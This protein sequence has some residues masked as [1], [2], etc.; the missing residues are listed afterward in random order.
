[1]RISSTQI[2]DFNTRTCPFSCL[3][4]PLKLSQRATSSCSASASSVPSFC[5][6]G[7]L[8]TMNSSCLSHP[9]AQTDPKRFTLEPPNKDKS[10][11]TPNDPVGRKANTPCQS[12][13]PGWHPG[14]SL[15]QAT[16]S[17]GLRPP[18]T[19]LIMQEPS[20]STGFWWV[21]DGGIP[22]SLSR[23]VHPLP[24]ANLRIPQMRGRCSH[25]PCKASTG[26]SPKKA[27]RKEEKILAKWLLPKRMRKTHRKQG[28]PKS[29]SGSSTSR[30]GYLTLAVGIKRETK[31]A[32]DAE[33]IRLYVYE[34]SD[35]FHI[36]VEG[37]PNSY[38]YAYGHQEKHFQYPQ[39]GTMLAGKQRHSNCNWHFLM[40]QIWCNPW[41]YRKE[42]SKGYR[43]CNCL[44]SPPAVLNQT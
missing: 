36:K 13:A 27:P 40:E 35:W 16:P 20:S 19:H 24:P 7:F 6:T 28:S 37:S 11:S 10:L 17:G 23:V 25:V 3:F 9:H 29:Q 38:L 33:C 39:S 12:W 32:L 14:R 4:F 22:S 31:Q 41:C 8:S 34:I 42:T 18:Q 15:F 5:F 26:H 2:H 21:L 44:L 30:I 1:M 43:D